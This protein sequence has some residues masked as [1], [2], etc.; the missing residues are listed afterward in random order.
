MRHNQVQDTTSQERKTTRKHDPHQ[1]SEHE[2]AEHEMTQIPFR[3]CSRH[4]IRE[5][6]RQ[7]DCR[8]TIE[9][10]R[11]APEKH[12]DHMCICDEKEGNTVAFLVARER[13]TRPCSALWSRG[14]PRETGCARGRGRGFEESDWSPSTSL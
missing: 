3:S 6:G 7:K 8:R 10:Q 5:T 9:E 12:L 1:P 13:E 4:C 2:R 11:H 14:S